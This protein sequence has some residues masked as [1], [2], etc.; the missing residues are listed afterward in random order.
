MDDKSGSQEQLEF[1]KPT[2]T[3]EAKIEQARVKLLKAVTASHLKT[4]EE[5]V[6]WILNNYPK[7]RD[8]DITLQ[9]RYWNEFESSRFD[10]ESVSVKDYYKLTKLTSLTR[11]RQKI[12]NDLKLFQASPEVEGRRKKLEAE[13]LE[14]AREP[15]QSLH[16]FTVYMDESGK[17]QGNLIVGTVWY[18]VGTEQLKF[19]KLIEEWKV[20]NDFQKEFHFNSI[21]E[22]KLNT[23][24][25]FADLVAANA[26]A[27]SFRIISVEQ[28]G[29]LNQQDALLDLAYLLLV[30]SIERENDSGR[31]RLPRGIQFCSDSE[32]PGR[33]KLFVGK[34]A[35]RMKQAAST[36]FQGKLFIEQFTT[37]DSANNVH[38]QIAD[39]FTSSVNRQL[40]AEGQRKHPKD[41][42]ADYFLQRLGIRVGQGKAESFGDK[43]ALIVL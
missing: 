30:R 15:R 36:V 35:E 10:L 24:M 16:H 5:R 40:N 26:G 37:D 19:F 27:V 4:L 39:L 38:L 29:I 34:L 1:E 2:M 14:H 28:S 43:T 42:F 41:Q 20:A 32:Q 8:S 7:T 22:S 33:D 13:Q 23:Y 9:L 18:L 3:K 25:R 17:T 6:A 12:Q 31:A 11:A 21:N